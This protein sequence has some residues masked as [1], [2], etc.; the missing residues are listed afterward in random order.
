MTPLPATETACDVLVIGAGIVGVASA[1][2]LQ[3]EGRQVLLIDRDGVAAQAS[4]GNAG[5]LA[6]SNI[7]P[8]ASPGI[9]RSAPRW[10][11]APLGPLAIRPS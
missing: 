2:R 9:M 4:R 8:L 11:L 5:A 1:L 10:L 6:F 3:Q 7:M